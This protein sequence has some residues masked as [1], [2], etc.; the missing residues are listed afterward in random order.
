MKCKRVMDSNCPMG[1]EIK[2]NIA[3]KGRF[4]MNVVAENVRRNK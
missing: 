4:D 3:P 1:K 2:F